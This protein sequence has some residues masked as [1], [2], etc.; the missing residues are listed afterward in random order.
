[1]IVRRRLAAVPLLSGILAAL[2]VAL[3]FGSTEP[4]CGTDAAGVDACR[5]IENARCAATAKC[6][7]LGIDPEKCT[8]FYR[9]EC[10]HGIEN[11]SHT[12]ADS[13]IKACVDA[14]N[15]A[16]ACAAT[17][18]TIVDCP[19]APLGTN[20]PVCIDGRSN[21]SLTPCEV[22]GQCAHVLAACAWVNGAAA[23]DAGSDGSGGGGG[24]GGATG[25]GGHG[26]SATATGTGGHGGAT[27]TGTGGHGGATGTGGNGGSGGSGGG[28]NDA[29]AG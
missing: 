15:A 6:P 14:I 16:A 18:K 20:A 5:Q 29:G 3:A 13:E 28:M 10:L 8:S 1:M 23:P 27:A 2:A 21:Q 7:S 26:G 12:P 22:I 11:A 19:G 9:D 17:A 4:G 24:S 25:T